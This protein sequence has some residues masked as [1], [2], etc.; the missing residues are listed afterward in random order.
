MKLRFRKCTTTEQCTRIRSEETYSPI[1]PPHYKHFLGTSFASRTSVE[2]LHV[3]NY[4]SKT[5]MAS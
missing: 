2:R 3:M 4:G 5:L 1:L